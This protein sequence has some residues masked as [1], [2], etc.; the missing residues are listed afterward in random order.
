[1][2]PPTRRTRISIKNKTI[3]LYASIRLMVLFSLA[4]CKS[5]RWADDINTIYKSFAQAISKACESRAELSSLFAESEISPID[6]R[7]IL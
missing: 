7:P 6:N 2:R 1:M 4:D 5:G 3:S